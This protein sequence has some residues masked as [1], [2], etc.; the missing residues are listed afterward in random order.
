MKTLSLQRKM[1]LFI[2]GIAAV[3][4]AIIFLVIIPSVSHI[5]NLKKDITKTEEFL[6][7]Q[8][9]KTRNLQKSV[10]RFEEILE[11]T[12][13][14]NGIAIAEGEE[15][16]VI[17]QLEQLAAQYNI[18]Q[19]LDVRFNSEPALGAGLRSYTFS[20]LN[21]GLFAD[22]MRYLKSFELLPYYLNIDS[23]DWQAKQSEGA[24]TLRFNATVYATL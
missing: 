19:N 8:Y 14:F 13:K 23:L 22:Q 21:L 20:F 24:V 12:K 7:E 5:K 11:Q 6:E 16:S 1:T 9:Q 18:E 3:L 4:I 15:L 10:R 2:I 17:T